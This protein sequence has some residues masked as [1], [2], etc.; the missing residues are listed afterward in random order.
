MQLAKLQ[1]VGP[2]VV[3]AM[4]IAAEAAAYALAQRPSSALAWYLNIE[5]F[6]LFQR[7]H[8]VLS[9][10][11]ALPYFQL[12]GVALPIL[13][14]A[15]GGLAC[16][17]PLMVATASNLS[18][19]YALFLAYAWHLVETPALVAASLGSPPLYA[20][21]SWSAV[22]LSSGLHALILLTMLIA[23]LFSCT[24]SH[25]SYLRAVRQAVRRM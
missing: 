19:V 12:V 3:A 10:R 24:A 4:I 5:V 21:L 13:F 23:S 22:T 1:L 25:L 18:L 14:L 9:D 2:F 15:G 7:G 8:Y 11:F 16:R 17:G 6:G 20:V